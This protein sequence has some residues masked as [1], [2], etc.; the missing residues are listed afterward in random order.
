MSMFKV[1]DELL[2]DFGHYKGH[3]VKVDAVHALFNPILYSC[4]L[5]IGAKCKYISLFENELTKVN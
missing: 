4:H 1:N 2:C 5:F 3:K